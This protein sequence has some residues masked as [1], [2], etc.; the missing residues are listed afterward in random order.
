[1]AIDGCVNV[2]HM[3]SAVSLLHIAN[4]NAKA[5]RICVIISHE[6]TDTFFD[7]VARLAWVCAETLTLDR[8]AY[9]AYENPKIRTSRAHCRDLALK[10]S[11]G[12]KRTIEVDFA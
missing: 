1:M 10:H 9:F 7:V 3:A 11:A 12:Q 4:H 5:T 6:S 8:D 2:V